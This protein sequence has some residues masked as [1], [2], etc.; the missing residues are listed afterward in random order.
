MVAFNVLSTPLTTWG[1]RIL[2]TPISKSLKYLQGHYGE[3]K[4]QLF[5]A[6]F[7]KILLFHSYHYSIYW[8]IIL[9]D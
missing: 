2:E 3:T 1:G 6:Q 8:I 7:E 9:F 5:L 4:H